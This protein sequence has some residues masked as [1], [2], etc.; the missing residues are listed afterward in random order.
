M[1]DGETTPSVWKPSRDQIQSAHGKMV[2]DLLAP[3]L[4]VLFS[5][6]NPSLYSAA[7]GHHFARPGNRFWPTLYNS[8]FT[9]RL[10]SPFEDQMLLGLGYGIT[11]FVDRATNAAAEL[12][13]E[14]FLEGGKRLESKIRRFSPTIV[15]FLGIM[16][17]R[18]AFDR[19]EAGIG[20]QP[21]KIGLAKLWVLPNPSGLNAHYQRG[22]LKV[23]FEELRIASETEVPGTQP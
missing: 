6:I 23:L 14:E 1:Q 15:A 9:P 7:V 8:R 19:P 20:L 3:S 5:G 21:E 4:K 11:N 10:F 12:G 22:D 18:S 2:P 13:A 16:A 17:Y